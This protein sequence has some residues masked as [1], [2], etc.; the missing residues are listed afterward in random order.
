MKPMR[1][2]FADRH[3]D[4]VPRDLRDLLATEP[5]AGPRDDGERRRRRRQRK[6]MT[7]RRAAP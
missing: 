4:V 6:V 7:V 5:A 3:E 1:S 2:P